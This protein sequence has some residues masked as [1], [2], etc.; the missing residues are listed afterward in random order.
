MNQIAELNQI[1]ELNAVEVEE[2]AGGIIPMVLVAMSFAG[3]Y[4]VGSII[5]KALR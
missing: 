3:G 4:S 1:V 5:A 2:V